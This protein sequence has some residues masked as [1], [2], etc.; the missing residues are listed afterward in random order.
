ME[1]KISYSGWACYW[2]FT[3]GDG[4]HIEIEAGKY[5]TFDEAQQLAERLSPRLYWTE[6]ALIFDG[7]SKYKLILLSEE[8]YAVI[9]SGEAA[10]IRMTLVQLRQ[11]QAFQFFEFLYAS[12]AP[13]GGLHDQR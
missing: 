3:C 4:F 9:P 6:N 10:P 1:Q 7:G 13:A 11:H 8:H 5:Q 2:V 12:F